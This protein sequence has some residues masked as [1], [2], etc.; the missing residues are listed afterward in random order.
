[1]LFT[2]EDTALHQKAF[3]A[4]LATQ[5]I[6]VSSLGFLNPFK[7][8]RLARLFRSNGVDIIII[9]D[10]RDLKLAGLA[11]RK[12]DV[13]RIIYRR[14][15][16]IPIRNSLSNRWIFKH[17]VND[18]IAN[19]HET[20]RTILKNNPRLFSKDKIHTV[21]NGIDL[22]RFDGLPSNPLYD[23]QGDEVIIGHAGR[24][25]RQKGQIYLLE[26]ACMLKEKGVGFKLLIAGT[27]PLEDE[28]K[29]ETL[30]R[31]LSENVIF[32]GFT[33][34]I[35]D[36][37]HA[38]DI[39]VLPSLW[40]GFGYVLIEAMAC[41]LP[42]V[43]FNNSSNPEIVTGGETG[44]LV[45]ADNTAAFTNAVISLASN[46]PLRTKMGAA[47]RQRVEKYFTLNHSVDQIEKLL[48]FP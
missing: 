20:A 43:A 33:E 14:G 38:S 22:P 19:S 41:Q 24:L 8:S 45:E 13:K 6:R 37:M 23:R 3:A 17:L 18:I 35:K 4:G 16:A 25:T 15:S 21:Y 28:L 47:G 39:F 9:N 1:M 26:M 12:A 27:G 5:A 46:K 44:I 34:N 11:A 29:N 2:G 48:Q 30:A 36:L 32:P 31:K 40:E 7:V 42:V 10:S